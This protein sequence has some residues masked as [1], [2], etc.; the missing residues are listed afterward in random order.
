MNPT[1]NTPT[2][3]IAIGAAVSPY[4]LHHLSELSTTA[5]P[6]LGCGWL[7]IQASVYLYDTF[8]KKTKLKDII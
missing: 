2:H 7:I 4:W 5:L 3:L 6:I 1:D 8:I